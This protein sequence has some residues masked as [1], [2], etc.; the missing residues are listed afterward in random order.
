MGDKRGESDYRFQWYGLETIATVCRICN[1][2]IST[3]YS[4]IK[5]VLSGPFKYADPINNNGEIPCPRH[6][7][8]CKLIFLEDLLQYSQLLEDLLQYSQLLEDLLQYSQLLED[9]YNILS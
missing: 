3:Y 5:R 1:I 7:L 2:S 6:F 8:Q 9:S 4:I